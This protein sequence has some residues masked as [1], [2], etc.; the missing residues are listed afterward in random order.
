MQAVNEIKSKAIDHLGIVAA[1][2]DKIG[3]IEKIDSRIPVSKHK[4]AKVTVG[5]CVAAMLLN[6][7]GF[8]DRRLYM[9]SDFLST[10]PVSDLLGNHLRAEDFTDD[11]LGRCLDRIYE[12][13]ITNL[14]AELSLEVASQQGLLGRSVHLDTTSLGVYGDYD[15]ELEILSEVPKPAHGF[16]K[17]GLGRYKQMVLMMATSGKASMP[18]WME[19]LSGNVSDKVSLHATAMRLDAFVKTLEAA[20]DFICVGDSAIFDACLKTPNKL[21]WLT[22]ASENHK[23]VKEFISTAGSCDSPEWRDLGNGYKQ[24]VK[25]VQY[26]G[27]TQRWAL[28]Y[29][30]QAYQREIATLQKAVESQGAEDQ[31]H[32]KRLCQQ[33]FACEKDARAAL[34]QFQKTLKYHS[35]VGDVEVISCY[36]KPGRPSKSSPP[37]ELKYKINAS[38]T[39]DDSKIA[40]YRN[41]KGRFVLSTNVLNTTTLADDELLSVYKEQ[42]DPEKGFKFIKDDAFEVSGVFL[43]KPE[44]INALM[45]IM[46]L[47]L[48]VYNLTQHT[49]RESLRLLDETIPNQLKKP[50]KN[51]TAK[52]TFHF[53]TNVQRLY[54]D[55]HHEIVINLRQEARQIIGYFGPVAARIYNTC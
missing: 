16:S 41:R 2:L 21:A 30:E 5:E 32:L 48:L 29:S 51:P 24:I 37:A 55:K 26:R 22:R 34:I 14:F 23:A 8:V 35:T 13:G 15:D 31:G 20:P 7:L 39:L 33:V 44:R 11:T 3:L 52:W 36:P 54:L 40:P 6:G 46:V 18:I 42:A 47:C 50:I 45:M 9:F 28:I 25:I 53:F 38:L 10:K 1:T 19:A 27:I 17:D 12:Y 4:G 43:K 49:V